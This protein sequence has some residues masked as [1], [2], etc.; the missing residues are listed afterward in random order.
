VILGLPLAGRRLPAI[1]VRLDAFDDVL[2]EPFMPNRA[3]VALDVGVLLWLSGLDALDSISLF[4]IPYQQLATDVLRSV[5][6]LYG[7][8]LAAPLDDPIEASGDAFGGQREVDLNAQAFPVEV[9]QH[10]QQPERTTITQSVGHEV[11]SRRL[12]ANSY[13]ATHGPGHVWRVRDCQRIRFV[14]L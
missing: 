13:R 4:L 5:V 8:W 12:K 9:V 6:D 10:V 2:V 14:P 7:A 3:V 1:A 11:P